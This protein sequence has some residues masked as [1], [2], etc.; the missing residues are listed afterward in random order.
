MSLSS[1]PWVYQRWPAIWGVLTLVAMLAIWLAFGEETFTQ[2]YWYAW[3][4]ISVAWA[5]EFEEYFIG[6][7][8]RWYNR[9]C[10]KSKEDYFPLTHQRAFLINGSSAIP[11]VLQAFLISQ[12]GFNA[13]LNIAAIVSAPFYIWY[14]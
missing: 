6:N 7:F 14:L 13:L 10:F 9:T 2:S 1:T 3:V 5:H 11:L 8:W 12:W 4:L